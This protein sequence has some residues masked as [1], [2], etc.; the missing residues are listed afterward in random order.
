MVHLALADA[1]G[2]V[3]PE[4]TQALNALDNNDWIPVAGGMGVFVLAS[5]LAAVRYRA[6]PRWLAWAGFVIGILVF[7]P[8]GFFAFLAAGIWTLVTSIVL[9]TSRTPA[10]TD[11]PGRLPA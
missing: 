5:G 4:A 1:G 3:A 2:D 7:T 10:E 8:A 11:E 6:L 9:L